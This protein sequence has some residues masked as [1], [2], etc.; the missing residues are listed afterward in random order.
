MI[1][2][3]GNKSLLVTGG[4]CL[5]TIALLFSGMLS[6]RRAKIR[7]AEKEYLKAVSA[8]EI[9]NQQLE[10]EMEKSFGGK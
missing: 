10:K 6:E 2:A 9:R 5:A 3:R 4:A 1:S 7:L 8:L